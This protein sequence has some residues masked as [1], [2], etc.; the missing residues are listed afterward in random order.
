MIVISVSRRLLRVEPFF[1]AIIL[2]LRIYK[3][4][5]R[6]RVEPFF[7]AI[8]LIHFVTIPDD[9]LRVEPFFKAIILTGLW[10]CG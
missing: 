2:K 8:I 7:K 1:K 5:T 3:W 6:L 10:L 4:K 9:K